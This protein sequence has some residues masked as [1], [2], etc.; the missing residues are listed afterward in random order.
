[1]RLR[2]DDVIHAYIL[3]GFNGGG[4]SWDLN[5]N[6]E[7][8]SFEA[9]SQRSLILASNNNNDL[10]MGENT[11]AESYDNIILYV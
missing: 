7:S 4:A 2:L 6:L 9:Q 8:K 10:V 3:S 5:S 1:M 11:E